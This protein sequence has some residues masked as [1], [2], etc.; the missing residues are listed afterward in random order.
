V[1]YSSNCLGFWLGTHQCQD[2]WKGFQLSSQGVENQPQGFKRKHTQEN[3]ILVFTKNYI[4][5]ANTFA[6]FEK[7]DALFS[8]DLCAIGQE[9][10]MLGDRFDPEPIENRVGTTE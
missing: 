1:N 4:G 10:L 9:K 8:H 7:S 2:H 5:A 3:T 6:V